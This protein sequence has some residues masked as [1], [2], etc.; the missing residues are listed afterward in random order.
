VKPLPGIGLRLDAVYEHGMHMTK[1]KSSI[2]SKVTS[3]PVSK[4]LRVV[5][6]EVIL[7]EPLLIIGLKLDA[8]YEHGMHIT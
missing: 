7:D 5:K 3:H 1:L 4:S 6:W 8:V 2:R